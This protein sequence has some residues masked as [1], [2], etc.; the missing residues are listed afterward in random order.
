MNQEKTTVLKGDIITKSEIRSALRAGVFCCDDCGVIHAID[1]GFDIISSIPDCIECGSHSYKLMMS[2]EQPEE[3]PEDEF[4]IYREAEFYDMDIAILKDKQGTE[5]FVVAYD[6]DVGIEDTSVGRTVEIKCNPREHEGIK[7]FEL[8]DVLKS[9]KGKE[10]VDKIL[11]E[12]GAGF[13]ASLTNNDIVEKIRQK[14]DVLL[15]YDGDVPYEKFKEL[16]EMLDSSVYIDLENH[17]Y[18]VTAH[19]LKLLGYEKWW[20]ASASPLVFSNDG[21]C[22][23]AQLD[24]LRPESYSCLHGIM[25]NGYIHL[26]TAGINEKIDVDTTILAITDKNSLEDVDS[27]IRD[28]FDICEI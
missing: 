17:E 26:A 24:Q 16:D 22:I 13:L 10:N 28:Q 5:H 14:K 21:L 4:S 25:N 18:L 1:L 23:M 8:L 6:Q 27:H 12:E 7:F 20:S 19:R 2:K 9:V 11:G 15:V 3:Q